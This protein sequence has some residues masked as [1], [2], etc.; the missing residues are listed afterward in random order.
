VL[1]CVLDALRL[2]GCDETLVVLGTT[3]SDL[4]PLARKAGAHVCVLKEETPHM[5]ATVEVGLDWLGRHFQPSPGDAWLLAPADHPTLD[6][7]VVSAVR[8][9]FL[10]QPDKSI[11]VPTFAGKRGHPVLM[12]W[13]HVAAVRAHPPGE[14]LN[15][16]LRRHEAET[17]ELPVPNPDVLADL[18]TPEDYARLL[19]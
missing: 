1:E 10:S 14:G 9:A 13:N 19:G 5:R 17:L 2:G 8:Q 7:A 18:D 6:P 12:S 11:V 16:Y 3:V 4:E 15:T